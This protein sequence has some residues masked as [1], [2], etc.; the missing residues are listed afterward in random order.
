VSSFGLLTVIRA[1]QGYFFFSIL[2]ALGIGI[3]QIRSRDHRR[4]SGWLRERVFA[5]VFVLGFYCFVHIFEVSSPGTGLRYL[6]FLIT[7]R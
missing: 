3:S 5:P 1:F 6:G 4:S 7:G 2:L